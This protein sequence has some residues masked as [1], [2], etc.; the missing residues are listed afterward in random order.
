ME[1]IKNCIQGKFYVSVKYCNANGDPDLDNM[2]RTDSETGQG[3]ITDV[4]VKRRIRDY[5]LQKFDGVPGM[6]VIIR[7]ASN[8][9][10]D[11]RKI[12]DA[13]DAEMPSEDEDDS[14]KKKGKKAAST[15]DRQKRACKDFW[16]IR[17][18][19]AVLSTGANA[20]QVKGAVQF[21]MGVSIDPV[22]VQDSGIT[23]VCRAEGNKTDT[24]EKLQADWDKKEYSE[25]HTMGRKKYV[26][27]GLYEICFSVS[28]CL[29]EKVGFSDK[30]FNALLEGIL[31]MYEGAGRTSSK[32][33]MRVVTPIIL[34]KHVGLD[35]M[36]P[37]E[38]ANAVKLGCASMYDCL[39]TVR[40]TRKA[41]V[42][43][44]RSHEDYDAI[45]YKDK[46]P[47]G[48]QIGFKYGVYEDIVWDIP[49]ADGWIQVR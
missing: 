14:K 3:I 8:I 9:N 24:V 46:L 2:P 20:G 19:G 34:F 40:I 43:V 11:I 4:A 15:E 30:D 26:E 10:I 23:R 42:P 41:D 12:A 18:F 28:A 33:G 7:D 13:V 21:D 48:V 29:A 35:T 49:R 16:D 6:G 17:T 45:F 39:D 38:R 22:N 47:K 27:F 1:S 5:V 32:S 36:D 44:A 31:M 25:K 37:T